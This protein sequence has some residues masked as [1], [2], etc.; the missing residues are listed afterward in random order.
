MLNAGNHL[1][2]SFQKYVNFLYLDSL[3]FRLEQDYMGRKE[4]AILLVLGSSDRIEV[5]DRNRVDQ[6]RLSM[7]LAQNTTEISPE[8]RD[9]IMIILRRGSKI[10]ETKDDSINSG[11]ACL[12]Y[13]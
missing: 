7:L 1:Q 4:L 12:F 13:K 8:F 2:F 3:L 6:L 11:K 9:V 5:D 10:R